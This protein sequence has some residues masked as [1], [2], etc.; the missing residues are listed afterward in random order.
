MTNAY[1]V[2]W[3]RK[4]EEDYNAALALARQRKK[5]TPNAVTFHC[6]Q[7]AEKYLKAFLVQS[8][9]GFPKTH[10]LLELHKLCLGVNPAFELIGDLLDSLNPYAVEFRYPGD[11][12]NADEAQEAIGAVKEVRRFMRSQLGDIVNGI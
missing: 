5:S 7:C 10:D 6:Q 3:I 1:L 4:A 9:V 12:V 11:E 2:E 8:G